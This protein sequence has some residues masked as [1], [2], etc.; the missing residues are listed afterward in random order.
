MNDRFPFRTFAICLLLCIAAW[1]LTIRACTAQTPQPPAEK[2]W[3]GWKKND[4]RRL[5]A[6]SLCALGGIAWGTHEAIYAD[7]RVLEKRFGF[8]PRSWGGSRA[9]ELKY[10]GG[11]YQEGENPVFFRDKTNIFRE[12][13]KTTAFA[14]RYLPITAGIIITAQKD[15]RWTDYLLGALVY[16]ASATFTYNLLR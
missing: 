2:N 3:Y 16:S 12:A 13:K 4:F 7:P 1:L 5:G 8:K 15:R 9:W 10:P 14:G 11:D 6:Y